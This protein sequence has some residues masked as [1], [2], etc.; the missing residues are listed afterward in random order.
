MQRIRS[1]A[2]TEGRPLNPVPALCVL[3]IHM[4]LDLACL[5]VPAGEATWG[6]PLVRK[7][8]PRPTKAEGCGHDTG[9]DEPAA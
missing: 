1:L 5:W 8:D 2:I 9:L 6:Q 7:S 3:T 4:R